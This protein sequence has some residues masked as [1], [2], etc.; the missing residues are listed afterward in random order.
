MRRI[1]KFLLGYTLRSQR[2]RRWLYRG[3]SENHLDEMLSDEDVAAELLRRPTR[4][5]ELGGRLPAREVA[6]NYLHFFEQLLSSPSFWIEIKKSPRWRR[7]MAKE[8]VVA[9][10]AFMDREQNL[11]MVQANSWEEILEDADLQEIMLDLESVWMRAARQVGFRDR[12][13]RL[14]VEQTGITEPEVS[15]QQAQDWVEQ[16]LEEPRERMQLAWG[17]VSAPDLLDIFRE[18]FLPIPADI[19]ALSNG[20]RLRDDLRALR[21]QWDELLIDHATTHPGLLRLFLNHSAVRAELVNDAGIMQRLLSQPE[22]VEQVATNGSL[23]RRL[24]ADE[25]HRRAV[26][27]QE[28]MGRLLQRTS[29]D[30]KSS[31][32]VYAALRRQPGRWMS[33]M[34]RTFAVDPELRRRILERLLPKLMN[35]VGSQPK[36]VKSALDSPAFLQMLF[37]SE[38]LGLH[39]RSFRSRK[40]SKDLAAMI[41][42]SIEL[43]R[44]MS[45]LAPWMEST[46]FNSPIKNNLEAEVLA[47]SDNLWQHVVSH[48]TADGCIRLR[49]GRLRLPD[50][51]CAR[52]LLNELFLEEVYRHNPR[53]KQVKIIDLGAHVGLTEYYL[54]ERFPHAEIVAVEADE[55]NFSLLQD[56]CAQFGWSQVQLVHAAVT[57]RPGEVNFCPDEI[58]SMAGHAVSEASG[59]PQ[60][61][62]VK[63]ITLS[64]LLTSPTSLLK[65]DIEGAEREVLLEARD[66]LPLAEAIIC[67]FHFKHA[68]SGE[69]LM[70]ILHLLVEKGFTYYLEPA[71]SSVGR[72]SDIQSNKFVR[73]SLTIRAFNLHA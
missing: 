22:V 34:L 13:M 20:R 26:M 3:L 43:D 11:R 67:E 70:Q 45:G 23:W 1:L 24:A 27:G 30:E 71:Y 21:H 44:I 51:R 57:G 39:L 47:T 53:A 52:I 63:S 54:L 36:M 40:Y 19:T 35:D 17:L 68:A 62:R 6:Q 64:S 61:H 18:T 4:L 5:T 8:G 37:K 32:I 55:R 56:N 2:V 9:S 7:V 48:V 42:R 72:L 38:N 29:G 10:S 33:E 14:I 46:I 60:V 41:P 69:D 49:R 28:G 50:I 65:I 59:I 12:T 15:P 16:L 31:E 25:E 58:D 73:H 66:E